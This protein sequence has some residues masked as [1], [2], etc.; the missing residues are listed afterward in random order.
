MSGPG[1]DNFEEQGRQ[2]HEGHTPP[3]RCDTGRLR[4][5]YGVPGARRFCQE[6]GL[7]LQPLVIRFE[8]QLELEPFLRQFEFEFQLQSLLVRLEFQFRA[9]VLRLEFQLQP[10]LLQLESQIQPLVRRVEL[11]ELVR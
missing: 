1:T 8:L 9:F 11:Q 2:L 10:L 7:Q 4:A 3:G 5:R 6:L